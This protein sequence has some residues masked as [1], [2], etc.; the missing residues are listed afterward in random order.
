MCFCGEELRAMKHRLKTKTLVLLLASVIA[1]PAHPASLQE[2]VICTAQAERYFKNSVY[3]GYNTVNN[4]A[5]YTVFVSHYDAG[6]QICFV[7]IEAIWNVPGGVS[8]NVLREERFVY[9]AIG[10]RHYATFSWHSGEGRKYWEVPPFKCHITTIS[11][12]IINC[13]DHNEFDQL[14]RKTFGIFFK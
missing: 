3:S 13:K 8:G 11:G 5:K 4:P 10:G 9:D 7:G 2:Q 6:N 12:E 1:P 14:A